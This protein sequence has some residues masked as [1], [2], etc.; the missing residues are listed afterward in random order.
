MATQTN[1]YWKDRIANNTWKAYNKTE[2][3][4]QKLVEMYK[5]AREEIY[6]ELIKFDAATNTS[7][8]AAYN[9]Q[10]QL[11][12]QKQMNEV[13]I[14]LGYDIETDF[15]DQMAN[16]MAM[17]YKNIST[18][19]AG[20][21][22]TM[23]K[24]NVFKDVLKEPWKGDNFSGRLWINQ[25][26]LS[27]ALDQVIINGISAGKTITEM[28]VKLDGMMSNGLY[29]A[30]RLVR[31]ETMHYLNQATLMA[32]KD[33]GV[34][35]VEYLAALDERT[36]ETCGPLNGKTYAISRAP[37]LPI[38]P[39]CR[40]TYIPV[41]VDEKATT[42]AEKSGTI[43]PR[44][45]V[46]SLSGQ[47]PDDFIDEVKDILEKAPDVCQKVWNKYQ[48]KITI[49]NYESKRGAFYSPGW[50]HVEF[51]IT[52]DRNNP[53]G[54]MTTIF[55]ELGHLFDANG[56][57]ETYN[58]GLFTKASKR[59]ENGKLDVLLKKEADNLIKKTHSELKKIDKT[60]PKAQAYQAIE[61]EIRALSNPQKADISDIFEGVTKGKINGGW[62]HGKAYWKNHDPSSEAFAEMYSASVNNPESLD[63]IKK[64][65]P[66]SYDLFL[67][68]L[69]EIAK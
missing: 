33:R 29:N 26:K 5:A 48:D 32:Y 61:S 20:E 1:P 34:K 62:G 11:A 54:N 41:I 8:T 17:K 13:I 4:N 40:C 23:L 43:K 6:N 15:S 14:Q 16:V 24:E 53:A 65:F 67:E 38:H 12:L 25:D 22:F 18:E 58:S 36:C 51:S 21:N 66:E 9:Y 60:T 35:R 57:A 63:Q 47:L 30:Y 69:K 50:N 31:T 59:F 39:N 56:G 49:N 42:K 27:Q 64:Y 44:I 45:D 46:S 37:I 68:I 7:R 2:I 19:L 55:H 28:A 52:Q 10:R 3:R